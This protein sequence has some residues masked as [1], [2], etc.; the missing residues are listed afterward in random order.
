M[1]VRERLVLVA[2]HAEDGLLRI[3]E[4]VR[5]TAGIDFPEAHP[6]R[7]AK[8]GR[9]SRVAD[10]ELQHRQEVV[11]FIANALTVNV[12]DRQREDE[13]EDEHCCDV[14]EYLEEGIG[15]VAEHQ[16]RVLD[17]SILVSGQLEAELLQNALLDGEAEVGLVLEATAAYTAA[18]AGLDVHETGLLAEG[19]HVFQ[20]LHAFANSLS[21]QHRLPLTRVVMVVPVAVRVVMAVDQGARLVNY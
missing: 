19:M 13:D 17:Y 16:E 20:V 12:E 6:R 8:D 10:E 7:L 2:H 21:G 11:P 15:A 14:A 9:A 5:R 18:E 3:E 4:G 1:A